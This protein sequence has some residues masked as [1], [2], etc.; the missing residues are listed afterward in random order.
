MVRTTAWSVMLALT[1]LLLGAGVARASDAVKSTDNAL[2]TH[3][4]R[5]EGARALLPAASSARQSLYVWQVD[6]GTWDGQALDGLSLVLVQQL[7]EDGRPAGQAS[8]YVSDF[9]TAGQ[10]DALVSALAASNPRLFPDRTSAAVRIEPAVIQVEFEGQTII[11]HLG[12]I[13]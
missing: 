4:Y 13:A 11:L 7:S 8:I 9:A 5:V 1:A 12:L 3:Q 10:R 6:Q 2:V